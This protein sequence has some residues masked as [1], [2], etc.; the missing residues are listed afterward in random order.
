M[1]H[2]PLEGLPAGGNDEQSTRFAAGDECLLDRA[3]SGHQLLAIADEPLRPDFRRSRRP[4]NPIA[5]AEAPLR[6]P[7]PA[8]PHRALLERR[9]PPER[10]LTAPER[11]LSGR[12]W[13]PTIG[14]PA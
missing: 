6:S 13:A 12:A 3:P 11:S 9:R 1:E 5:V 7:R 8:W 14:G 10:S 4:A 2:D